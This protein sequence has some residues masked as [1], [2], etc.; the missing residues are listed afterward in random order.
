MRARLFSGKVKTRSPNTE[1]SGARLELLG[2]GPYGHNIALMGRFRRRN[3]SNKEACG[4]EN[5]AP[6]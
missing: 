2:L 5:L 4:R 3:Q 1:G 6:V